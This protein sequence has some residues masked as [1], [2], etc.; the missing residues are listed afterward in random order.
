MNGIDK[1][2]ERI[3]QKAEQESQQIIAE[4]STEAKNV[5]ESLKSQGDLEAAEIVSRGEEQAKLYI[6][7][8]KAESIRDA[9]R[10]LLQTKQMMIDRAFQRAKELLMELSDDEYTDL[11][12]SLALKAIS[13]GDEQLIFGKSDLHRATLIKDK[14]NKFASD[15]GLSAN[16]TVMPQAGNFEGGLIVRKGNV[17]TNCTFDTIIRTLRDSM[18][19]EVASVLFEQENDHETT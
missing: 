2:I 9:N 10:M 18:S 4:A 6:E 17:D 3:L 16:I 12:A 8:A 1:I 7:R 13:S 14:V 11:L 5:Y 15:K 19:G